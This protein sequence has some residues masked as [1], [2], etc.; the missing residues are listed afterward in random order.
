MISANFSAD[1][2]LYD[3]PSG[4]A[5]RVIRFVKM[6]RLWE[7]RYA[8]SRWPM[9][10]YQEAII[11]RIYGPNDDEGRRLT[12]TAVIWMPRGQA[13]TALAGALAL[14]H[15]MGPEREQGG[16]ILMAARDREQASF[17]FNHAF[18]MAKNDRELAR[19]TRPNVSQKRLMHPAT[20]STLR[21]IPADGAAIQGANAS[22]FIADEI[23]A[24]MPTKARELYSAVEDGMIKRD[25]PLTIV[26]STAGGGDGGLARELW[27]YSHKVARGEV[28]DPSF[29]PIIFAADPDADWQ[30]EATWHAANPALA[31]GFLSLAELRKKVG[32][33]AQTPAGIAGFKRYHLNIWSDGTSEPWL[34]MATYDKAEAARDPEELKGQI[35]YAG[36]DLSS[37]SDLTAGVVVFPIQGD[38]GQWSYDVKAHFWLPR[39]NISLKADVD[40]ANYLKWAE[41]G[42]ITLT[43]GNVVDHTALVAWC[44]QVAQEHAVHGLAIDR[45]NS[46]AVEVSLQR[47]GVN[48]H[49]FGQ[50]YQSMAAP[51]RE[52]E[53]AILSGKFRHAD[54]PVLRMCFANAEIEL[55]PTENMKL[56]KART[57]VTG[58][59]DGAVAA[60]MAIGEALKTRDM[61][62]PEVG[63]F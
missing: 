12:R 5:D 44:A 46:V 8:G 15:F 16:Q 6:L 29:A 13:K 20:T 56:T 60:V 4:R 27:D 54:N 48:V 31:E 21:A 35:C 34:P 17:A 9:A 41:E 14:A 52:M 59:I 50:G 53:R 3:D 39:D 57:R 19:R 61:A 40:Q 28:E 37:V 23:H 43:P 49:Q 10:R 32:R 18:Q 30:D 2:E 45:W 22:L 1:P 47:A 24:W 36:L 38:D 26:I 11:R 42:H 58:R 55:D 62:A 25:N 7:G 51:M 63:L 33:A